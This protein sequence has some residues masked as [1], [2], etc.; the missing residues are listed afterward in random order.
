MRIMRSMT[1]QIN[2]EGHPLWIKVDE[3]WEDAKLK[4]SETMKAE[5]AKA[6]ILGY[7]REDL[8]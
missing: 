8:G 6:A 4:D 1:I 5:D 3:I 2:E 7:C